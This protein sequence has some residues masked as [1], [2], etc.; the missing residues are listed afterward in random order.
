MASALTAGEGIDIADGV[1][2]FTISAEDA[3]DSN[4]GIAS[5]DGTN[6]TVSSGSVTAKNI[7]FSAGNDDAG[8]T[9]TTTRTLGGSLNIHGDF[10]Q[11]ITTIASAGQILV[12][13]RNA[14]VTSRGIA[15]FGTY[16]DS[17][18]EGTR[19]FTLTTGDVA[20]NAVDGGWY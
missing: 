5:F 11:G 4:K 19:Q 1:S 15:S 9:G 3:T 8:S 17:S 18:G 16:A 7:T 2:T 12:Q 14:T 10:D 13:G 20:I 6:F